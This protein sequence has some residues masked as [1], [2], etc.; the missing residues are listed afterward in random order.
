MT[1]L[2]VYVL[3][4]TACAMTPTPFVLWA[5]H[6]HNNHNIEISVYIMVSPFMFLYYTMALHASAVNSTAIK[7]Q[8]TVL[9]LQNT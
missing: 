8:K 2:Q 6:A 7:E 3:P 4:L 1:L 9:S 5:V